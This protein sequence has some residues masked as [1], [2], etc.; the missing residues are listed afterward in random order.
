MRWGC[1]PCEDIDLLRKVE[2]ITSPAEIEETCSLL[3]VVDRTFETVTGGTK[4]SRDYV[5]RNNMAG[6]ER[7]H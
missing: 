2:D 3:E 1:E 7:K 5:I 4:C 6:K